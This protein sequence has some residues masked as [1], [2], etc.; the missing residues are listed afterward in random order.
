MSITIYTFSKKRSVSVGYSHYTTLPRF[1]EVDAVGYR[2][3]LPA[4]RDIGERYR[5]TLAYSLGQPKKPP[6]IDTNGIF[7][8]GRGEAGYETFSF[9][10]PPLDA[11]PEAV[12]FPIREF[13]KTNYKDYD[14]VV[15]EM[16]LILKTYLPNIEIDS[17]GFSGYLEDAERDPMAVLDGSW[18]Q[19]IENVKRYNVT[20]TVSIK[21]RRA[22]YCD[23]KVEPI[24]SG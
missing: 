3:A 9:R 22:P 4:L 5:K 13:C 18:P 17:D 24:L 8:N 20:T 16:L 6:Q 12:E 23:L 1:A 21:E 7:L 10:L 11:K 2:Q 14:I 15:C 19:A